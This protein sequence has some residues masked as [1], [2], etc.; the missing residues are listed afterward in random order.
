MT[1][2]MFDFDKKNRKGAP[3]DFG[4]RRVAGGVRDTLRD[5]N[6]NYKIDWAQRFDK[7][8]FDYY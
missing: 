2:A 5:G 4:I 8:S 1:G 7:D 3:K 6:G